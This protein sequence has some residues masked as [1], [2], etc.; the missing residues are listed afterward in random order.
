MTGD[1]V[2]EAG[3][4]TAGSS[5]RNLRLPGWMVYA[6]MPVFSISSSQL[7]STLPGAIGS[8]GWNLRLLGCMV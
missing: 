3:C 7:P 2:G 8:S 6:V 4:E 5:D 1:M